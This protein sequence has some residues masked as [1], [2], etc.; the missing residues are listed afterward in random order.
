MTVQVRNENAQQFES[1]FEDYFGFQELQ[2]LKASSSDFYTTYTFDCEG[3][4][5]AVL[6]LSELANELK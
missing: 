6:L 4:Q 3:D 5:Y 1:D 2:K